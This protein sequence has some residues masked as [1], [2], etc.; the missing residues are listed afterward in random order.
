MTYEQPT[1]NIQGLTQHFVQANGDGGTKAT[2]TCKD[3]LGN[4]SSAGAYELD[5]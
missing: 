4:V 5:E 3:A 1:I 2:T